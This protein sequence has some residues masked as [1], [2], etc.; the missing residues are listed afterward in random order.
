[1][2]IKQAEKKMSAVVELENFFYSFLKLMPIESINGATR[3]IIDIRNREKEVLIKFILKCK[4]KVA[5]IN[6]LTCIN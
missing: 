3:L 5:R 6:D 4:S 1:M 2:K